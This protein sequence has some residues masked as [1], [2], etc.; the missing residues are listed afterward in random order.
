M[1]K[2][3]QKLKQN[4]ASISSSASFILIT[5]YIAMFLKISFLFTD[6]NMWIRCVYLALTL[7]WYIEPFT[8]IRVYI[9][10]TKMRARKS[11]QLQNS[12]CEEEKNVIF[13][14]LKSAA[15]VS[16]LYTACFFA[17]T[18]LRSQSV[19]QSLTHNTTQ[20]N[21]II[22]HFF[23]ILFFYCIKMKITAMKS[24]FTVGKHFFLSTYI[25][26]ATL[27]EETFFYK[28][29]SAVAECMERRNKNVKKQKRNVE[30]GPL[31]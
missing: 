22:F 18:A 26:S 2:N 23:T 3:V 16:S 28:E 21:L 5:I 14:S 8:F 17:I 1:C 25:K 7:L 29:R 15:L 24:L 19:S 30:R 6:R 4:W 13:S 9:Q 11:F 10:H 27:S 31:S 20:T 12:W